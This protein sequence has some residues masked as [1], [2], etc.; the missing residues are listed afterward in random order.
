[1]QNLKLSN[2]EE[3]I[4]NSMKY[5]QR[6]LLIIPLLLLISCSQQTPAKVPNTNISQTPAAVNNLGQE[7]PISAVAT[8]PDGTQI[9][10]E[11]TLTPNQQP[12]D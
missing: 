2:I 1:M 9:Q 11:V 6:F 10:L 5:Y 12:S 4:K 8:I 3:M 7:L